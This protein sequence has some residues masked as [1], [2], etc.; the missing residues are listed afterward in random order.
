M[1]VYVFLFGCVAFF[2]VLLSEIDDHSTTAEKKNWTYHVKSCAKGKEKPINLPVQIE[3][4]QSISIHWVANF[5]QTTD[6]KMREKKPAAAAQLQQ[7][8]QLQYKQK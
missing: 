5:E 1:N 4:N 8:E 2:I 7:I 6:Y 3:W